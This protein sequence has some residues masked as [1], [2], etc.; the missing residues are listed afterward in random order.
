VYKT[1]GSLA[2]APVLPHDRKMIEKLGQHL[3][4]L[5]SQRALAKMF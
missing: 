3:K 4:Q 2:G 1:L 5:K